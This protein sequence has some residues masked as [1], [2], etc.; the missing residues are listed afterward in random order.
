M[1]RRNKVWP[2]RPKS[3]FPKEESASPSHTMP[4]HRCCQENISLSEVAGDQKEKQQPK[5]DAAKTRNTKHNKKHRKKEPGGGRTQKKQHTKQP[6]KQQTK[7]AARTRQTKNNTTTQDT[8][9][10]LT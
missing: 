5:G 1:N 6:R 3:Y 2:N 8:E 7:K 10:H 4:S 9:Q